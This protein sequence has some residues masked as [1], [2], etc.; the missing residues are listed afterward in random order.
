[1]SLLSEISK[2]VVNA[3]LTFSSPSSSSVVLASSIVQPYVQ[4]GEPI[5]L[6]G[7][8]PAGW[9][10]VLGA[11]DEN[12]TTF[13]IPAPLV[14]GTGVLQ[15]Y[16]NQSVSPAPPQFTLAATVPIVGSTTSDQMWCSASRDGLVYAVGSLF[17]NNNTGLLAVFTRPALASQVWTQVATVTGSAPGALFASYVSISADG[18]VIAAGAYG[19]NGGA[20]QTTVYNFN[21]A[22]GSLTLAATLVGT[23]AVGAAAQGFGVSLSG[24]GLT[25][26]VGG[27]YDNNNVGAAWLFANVGGT[28]TQMEPKIVP[29]ASSGQNVGESVALSFDGKTLAIASYPEPVYMYS[30]VDG[31]WVQG[32]TIYALPR[33]SYGSLIIVTLSDDGNIMMF[34]RQIDRGGVFVYNR[35]AD[36]LWVQNG[37]I[38]VATGAPIPANNGQLYLSATS[39]TGSMFATISENSI[40]SNVAFAIFQ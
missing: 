13:G 14:D 4:A 30:L 28:W 15:V 38:R 40:P 29:L 26:A 10:Y 1:M 17:D 12:T 18:S 36:G 16:S 19:A 20:G 2:T 22:T 39:P 23:G 34:D 9:K 37:N 11:F 35:Q 8:N 6:P 31:A 24:D 5:I 3:T 7:F 21:R 27:V 32:Q 25:L 33:V